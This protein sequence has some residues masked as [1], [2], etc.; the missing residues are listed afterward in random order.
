MAALERLQAEFPEFEFLP[1]HM[2]E[3]FGR[4]RLDRYIRL[5]EAVREATSL[6]VYITLHNRPTPAVEEMM[7][8]CDPFVDVRCY[9]GHTMDDW[10]R[11]GHSFE[12][13]ADELKRSG[14]EAWTYYNIRGS[15]FKPEWTRLVNGFYLWLS[16]LKAHVPWMYYSVKGNP[17]DDTDGGGHDFVYA[18]PDPRN[19]DRLIST[20]HWEAFREGVDDQRYLGTLEELIAERKGTDL[21]RQAQAWLDRLRARLRPDP[22]KLQQVEGES[23]ILRTWADQ[24]DGPQYR[25]FRRDVADWIVRLQSR[26]AARGTGDAGRRDGT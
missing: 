15:F 22:E 23:P 8:R 2:D 3:V 16:P 20:R 18:V 25:R 26:D 7:R 9:N 10:I 14:D 11:A 5:T 6:R 1:T 24:F 4:N 17:L 12:Q 21:A 19:P 13:L